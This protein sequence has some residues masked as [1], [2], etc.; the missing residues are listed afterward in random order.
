MDPIYS[1][2]RSHHT[3]AQIDNST[4]ICDFSLTIVPFAFIGCWAAFILYN[5][6]YSKKKR[7]PL[8]SLISSL[9]MGLS[10]AIAGLFYLL[11][12]YGC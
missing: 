12:T 6:V 11:Q 7:Y 3:I 1:S 4:G 9:P 10:V 5:S 8:E 2:I